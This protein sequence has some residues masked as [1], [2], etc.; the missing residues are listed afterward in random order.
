MPKLGRRPQLESKALDRAARPQAQ[1]PPEPLHT[2]TRARQPSCKIGSCQGGSEAPS[3]GRASPEPAPGRPPVAR[4]FRERPTRPPTRPSMGRETFNNHTTCNLAVEP[5][6]TERAKS[7]GGAEKQQARLRYCKIRRPL[8]EDS[9]E[10]VFE[11]QD[12]KGGNAQGSSAGVIFGQ[13]AHLVQKVGWAGGWP[14]WR[15]PGC[16]PI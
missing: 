5:P 14:S 9:E 1:A 2:R 10:P 13:H 8:S 4:A 12:S 6:R 16:A 11:R 7:G 15:G 3:S